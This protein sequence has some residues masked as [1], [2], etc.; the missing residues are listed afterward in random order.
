MIM[1][2]P[3]LS[4]DELRENL[5][6]LRAEGLCHR[7][8]MRATNLF[9][10]LILYPGTEIRSRY[11]QVSEEQPSL[12]EDYYLTAPFHS[13]VV[14]FVHQV[15]SYFS[16]QELSDLLAGN[17]LFLKAASQLFWIIEK[18][19]LPRDIHRRLVDTVSSLTSRYDSWLGD[20]VEL[21]LDALALITERTAASPRLTKELREEILTGLEMRRHEF[22]KQHLGCTHRQFLD[23][24]GI[25]PDSTLCLPYYD[26][27]VILDLAEGGTHTISVD[28][29]CFK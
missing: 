14:G 28:M 3:E 9:N 22:D 20:L 11:V 16:S 7:D 6:F 21:N 18:D 15:Y 29:G 8:S 25:A 13:E 4:L 27:D 5:L 19:E 2:D 12:L 10:R 23:S 24:H 17:Q 26:G 1:F